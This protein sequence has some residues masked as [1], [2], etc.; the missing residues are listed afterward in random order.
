MKRNS[1]ISLIVVLAVLTACSGCGSGAQKSDKRNMSNASYQSA[2]TLEKD[3]KIKEAVAQ[4]QDMIDRDPA[5]GLAHLEAGILLHDHSL[6][7]PRAIYH[8]RRYLDLF[9][10]TDKSNL[11]KDRIKN[12]EDVL[13]SSIVTSRQAPSETGI[14]T[15]DQTK[16][17]LDMISEK[18]K[19]IAELK[20]SNYELTRKAEALQIKYD[21]LSESDDVGKVSHNKPPV[22]VYRQDEAPDKPEVVKDTVIPQK[23]IRTY[24]VRKEDSL[25]SIA[26]KMYKDA[27]LWPRIYDA[28]RDAIP[29]R[30]RLRV[31]QVLVVP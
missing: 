1:H 10:D 3:G 19:Q 27:E 12:A 30:N 23:T 18:D 31:G 2:K 6:D 25:S 8:Y 21:V 13:V 5:A 28:N 16:V 4:Y 17:Y 9:P 7:V 22:R 14:V 15:N 26:L 29:D 11:I 20:K 24:T